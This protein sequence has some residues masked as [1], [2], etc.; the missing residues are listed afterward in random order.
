MNRDVLIISTMEG[1]ENCACA[2]A[3]QTGS[4]VEVSGTRRDALAT[5]RQQEF[6]IVVV[7]EN[8]VEGDPVWADQIWSLSGLAMPVQI[9]FVLSGSAR[10]MREVKS[11]LNRRDGEH[12]LARRAATAE[13]EN[14]LKTS[15]TGLMLESELVLH[16]PSTPPALAPKLRRL[17]ELATVLRERLRGTGRAPARIG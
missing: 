2:I 17:V 10:L 8:L 3:E 4:R 15:V 7:E 6:G 11:A 12:A 13:L 16:E 9:N 5:L 14:E 1:V